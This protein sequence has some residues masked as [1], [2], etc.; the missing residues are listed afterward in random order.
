QGNG[1]VALQKGQE[2][3]P[4][5]KKPEGV[6]FLFHNKPQPSHTCFEDEAQCRNRAECLPLPGRLHLHTPHHP[7]RAPGFPA[8]TSSPLLFPE[9]FFDAAAFYLIRTIA[10][11]GDRWSSSRF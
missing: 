5:H 6:C 2:S 10:A 1:R 3:L 8:D 4:L 9:W 11:E 7:V